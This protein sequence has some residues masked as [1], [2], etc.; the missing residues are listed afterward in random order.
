VI[1]NWLFFGVMLVAAF[2]AQSEY[3]WL[4]EP[5][6]NIFSVEKSDLPLMVMNIF[7]S[8]IVLSAFVMVTLSGFVFFILPVVFLFW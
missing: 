2:L 6:M 8:N 3:A 5:P 7:F 4:Y 1:L